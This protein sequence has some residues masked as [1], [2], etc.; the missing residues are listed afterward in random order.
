[1]IILVDQ[2]YDF[3][4]LHTY[5]R[6]QSKQ[7][8]RQLSGCVLEGQSD[9]MHLLHQHILVSAPVVSG[10]SFDWHNR[11]DEEKARGLVQV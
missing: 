6:I 7:L 4:L 2:D 5:I 1:M 8:E 10:G 11:S 3:H 9:K